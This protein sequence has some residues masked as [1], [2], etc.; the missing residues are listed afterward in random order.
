MPRGRIKLPRMIGQT[1]AAVLRTQ[2]ESCHGQTETKLQ[3][4]NIAG[5]K[6]AE[7]GL[8]FHVR[9]PVG[10]H[11]LANGHVQLGSP[12][13]RVGRKNPGSR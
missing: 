3:N 9:R 8:A 11:V 6:R 1:L 12:R 7:R 4:R 2:S 5:A 13:I 10:T